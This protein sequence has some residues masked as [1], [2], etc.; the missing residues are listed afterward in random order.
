MIYQ[1]INLDREH[2]EVTLTTYIPAP[3]SEYQEDKKMPAVIVC[4]GGAY[5]FLSDR[6]GEPIA[7]KFNTEGYAAFVLRY[8]VGT[9]GE[10]LQPGPL[11]DLGRAMAYVK[12]HA[13]EW[14][15]DTERISICGF[16]AGGHLCASYASVW[17][18]S[19]FTGELKEPEDKLR[20]YAAILGY[21]VTDM[22]LLREK[23]R[24]CPTEL[25]E[26]THIAM[27]GKEDPGEEILRRYSPVYQ[28]GVRTVPCFIWHTAEDEL[29]D[30]RNSL[31]LA[32]A[33]YLHR[34]PFQLFVYP[35]GMHGLALSNSVT[36]CGAGSVRKDAEGWFEAMKTF[37][38]VLEETA[39]KG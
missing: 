26:L 13:R 34:I 9:Q 3:S 18:E 17:H 10:A 14:R 2:P 5:Q 27:F 8:R 28:V 1:T 12:E 7:L 29:V 20:P 36:D 23:N 4:P 22:L 6:E 21:P 31:R 25:M 37:L 33:L 24:E 35:C 38:E 11:F 19:W 15:I 39:A 32:E 30:L 16:S